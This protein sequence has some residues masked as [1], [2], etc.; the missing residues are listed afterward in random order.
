MST[1]VSQQPK[2]GDAAHDA[3]LAQV[4]SLG[5]AALHA[6]SSYVTLLADIN[7]APA[8]IAAARSVH[9]AARE[10]H[11]AAYKAA[12]DAA[13]RTMATDKSVTRY[14]ISPNDIVLETDEGWATFAR[15]NEGSA[16]VPPAEGISLWEF[17]RDPDIRGLFRVLLRAMRN[18]GDML[19]SYPFRCDSPHEIRHLLMVAQTMTDKSV[20]FTSSLTFNRE[21]TKE[22]YESSHAIP[23]ELMLCEAREAIC[24][25]DK[26]IDIVDAIC[27]SEVFSRAA[28]IKLV[29]CSVQCCIGRNPSQTYRCRQPERLW[30]DEP[31]EAQRL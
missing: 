1:V 31:M 21:N 12:Y 19:I 13:R 3:A 26:W 29:Q 30:R 24:F 22:S 8:I 25:E 9:S 10:A 16:L 6:R 5:A 4:A 17:V 2:A 11:D 23:L 14:V 28:S 15:E 27:G 20:V 18:R 7:A